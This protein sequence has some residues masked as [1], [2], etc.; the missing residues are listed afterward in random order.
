MYTLETFSEIKMEK[1]PF[2]KS[3]TFILREKKN[4]DLSIDLTFERGIWGMTD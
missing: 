4:T 3:I 1:Y 2:K